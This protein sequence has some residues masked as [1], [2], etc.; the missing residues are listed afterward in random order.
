M[1]PADGGRLR[2]IG[3]VGVLL[4]PSGLMLGLA[5][6]SG[7]FFPDS[8]S[9]AAV[10][11]LAIFSARAMLSRTALV[12]LSPGVLVVASALIAFTAWTLVSGSWS[13]SWARAMFAY[14]L[15]LLYTL[16]F[17]LIGT[18]GRS[19]ARARVLLFSL[20][21]VSVGISIAAVATWLLP[22]LFPVAR[23]IPRQRLAWPTSYWNVTGLIGALGLVWVFSLSCSSAER[24]VVRV[25]AA[26]AV[27]WPA[28]MLIFTASRGA[29]AVALLGL[30][31]ST[32]MIRSPATPGGVATAGPAIAVSATISLA[33]N[34]LNVNAPTPHAL[35]TGHRD[36]DPALRRLARGGRGPDAV[37]CA[38]CKDRRRSRSVDTCS[39]SGS[40]RRGRGDAGDCIPDPGW[41]ESG[42]HRGA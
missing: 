30:A 14:D 10:A 7:G 33:V 12:E 15:V 41:S 4:V 13:G 42:S 16:V 5:L 19:T 26:M 35:H 28:A 18:V 3:V 39:V 32:A 38:R 11:V 36:N 20:A 23:D 40:A 34:G 31:V 6:A 22:D 8:V 24:A 25:V 27:P 9:V 37:A 1:A 21:A 29:T 2:R 17:V